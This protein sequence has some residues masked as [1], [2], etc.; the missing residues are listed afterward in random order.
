[1]KFFPALALLATMTMVSV[2]GQT[3]GAAACTICLQK[4]IQALPLC[5][6]LNI[7]MGDFNPSENPAYAKCLCSTLDGAWIDSCSGENQC[8]QDIAAFKSAYAGNI[9][10]AGLSCGATPTFAPANL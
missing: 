10:A 4:S 6:G 9:Q 2:Q 3:N 1:M 8:G 5:S 7:T